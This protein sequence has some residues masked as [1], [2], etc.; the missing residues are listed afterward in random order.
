MIDQNN[1][2]IVNNFQKVPFIT[3]NDF[4][5]SN[6]ELSQKKYRFIKQINYELHDSI[7]HPAL[8]FA[9]SGRLVI[10]FDWI[11]FE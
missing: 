1:L 5:F 8:F 7:E 2:E 4:N 9:Q 3:L 6:K 11:L 10:Y